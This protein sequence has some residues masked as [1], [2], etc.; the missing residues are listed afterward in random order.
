M[1]FFED[2]E[3]ALNKRLGNYKEHSIPEIMS[4]TGLKHVI[5]DET[6][7]RIT[8]GKKIRKG[9][10]SLILSTL[11]EPAVISNEVDQTYGKVT[12]DLIRKLLAANR[13]LLSVDDISDSELKITFNV[14]GS[15]LRL[16][17]IDDKSHRQV[18]ISANDLYLQDKKKGE[19]FNKH[20]ANARQAL[21]NN[22]CDTYLI[23]THFKP[24]E[25]LIQDL[26]NSRTRFESQIHIET[27][28]EFIG[29][30][31]NI[32]YCFTQL[33]EQLVKIGLVFENSESFLDIPVKKVVDSAIDSN[34]GE[35]NKK[36]YLHDEMSKFINNEERLL[37]L[38]GHHGTGKTVE[39]LRSAIRL[40][41]DNIEI[42]ETFPLPVVIRATSFSSLNT[43]DVIAKIHEEVESMYNT[44]L[45]IALVDFL[46]KEGKL[47]IFIDGL[48]ESRTLSGWSTTRSFIEELPHLQSPSA[49]PKYVI[50]ARHELFE[51]NEIENRTF[52]GIAPLRYLLKPCDKDAAQELLANK[53]SLRERSEKFKPLLELIQ[54][55]LFLGLVSDVLSIGWKHAVEE[56]NIETI[57]DARMTFNSFGEYT[58]RWAEREQKRAT[59]SNIT[60][61][62][63]ERL[64]F[65]ELLASISWD[66]A[67]DENRLDIS[68]LKLATREHYKNFRGKSIIEGSS[69]FDLLLFDARLSSCLKRVDNHFEFPSDSIRLYFLAGNI[70]NELTDRNSKFKVLKKRKIAKSEF[71]LLSTFI[72]GGFNP[73]ND[74]FKT[75]VK[76]ATYLVN[77]INTQSFFPYCNSFQELRNVYFNLLGLVLWIAQLCQLKE[78]LPEI[79][80]LYL[81]FVEEQ[82][83]GLDKSSLSILV[84]RGNLEYSNISQVTSSRDNKKLTCLF[85]AN[86]DSALLENQKEEILKLKKYCLDNNI[87]TKDN[88]DANPH[89]RKI[90]L[91]W[92]VVPHGIYMVN[93]W[94]AAD[95][96]KYDSSWHSDTLR[97]GIGSKQEAS[98]IPIITDS[99]LLSQHPVTNGQ[100]LSFL[101]NNPEWSPQAHRDKIGNRWYLLGFNWILEDHGYDVKKWEEE[102]IKIED[103]IW[104]QSPVVSVTWEAAAHFAKFYG[105]FLPTESQYEAAIRLFHVSKINKPESPKGSYIYFDHQ[106]G[107]EK[108]SQ[109]PS[110]VPLFDCTVPNPRADT[111][112]DNYDLSV[113]EKSF[114]KIENEIHNIPYHLIGG[115]SEWTSCQWDPHWPISLKKFKDISI[116]PNNDGLALV[117]GKPRRILT[118][119]ENLEKGYTLRGSS[120]VTPKILFSEF[121]RGVQPISNANEDV[122]F[123]CV[124]PIY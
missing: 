83:F 1:T 105:C 65:C 106:L 77:I 3:A 21:K 89:A 16:K 23:I 44:S 4:L 121:Y 66:S 115:V 43:K 82:E 84:H 108:E 103:P 69:E 17:C 116:A 70:T 7:R 18:A 79:N 51:T 71:N 62:V 96:K 98:L 123:R 110:Y 6:F 109:P 61:S 39:C 53:T 75:P 113:F 104:Y 54:T 93:K 94:S 34:T 88:F 29:K 64:Q 102:K 41:E 118:M 86:K 117:E 26:R 27:V 14:A 5:S 58:R 49:K 42:Q 97:R 8:N 76:I 31:I 52:K 10:E 74:D 35:E 85:S 78:E 67:Y 47:I 38:L 99:F 119:P 100:F 46:I 50:T 120:Y 20:I 124:K 22:L 36:L 73:N 60:P 72:L 92:I 63:P 56:G 57:A 25:G 9:T 90:F 101:K 13:H 95:E 19:Y 32:G 12:C 114:A 2:F 37:V 15:T 91:K 122:G 30:F 59:A 87:L 68:A 81:P 111:N 107:K 11:N 24:S 55:P 40:L 112:P 28:N 80:R 33:K 45:P 48:D